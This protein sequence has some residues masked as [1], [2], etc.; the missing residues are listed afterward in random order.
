M[1]GGFIYGDALAQVAC[2]SEVAAAK[3]GLGLFSGGVFGGRKT[4]LAEHTRAG[5]SRCAEGRLPCRGLWTTR[6][7][8]EKSR[9]PADGQCERAAK[10]D[11]PASTARRC[12]AG[13][14]DRIDLNE[15]GPNYSCS[16][17]SPPH[18]RLA[19]S[20]PRP[21]ATAAAP[22]ARPHCLCRFA[23]LSPFLLSECWSDS[24]AHSSC[25]V[26]R[27]PRDSV[28]RT[29]LPALAGSPRDLHSISVE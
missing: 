17:S 29:C 10:V 3:D 19:T 23:R 12:E 1:A 6:K 11:R 18:D 16:C 21:Q 22:R 24:L 26:S 28:R 8:M 7:E 2:T 25:L 20:I 9:R 4:E 5:D 27:S 13:R 14:H 15:I